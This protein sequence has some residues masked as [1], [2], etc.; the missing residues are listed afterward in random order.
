[1]PTPDDERFEVYL[2]QFRP[3]VPDP[4]PTEGR[5]QASRRSFVLR[6]WIAA[7]AAILIVGAISLH[8][9]SNRVAAP[10]T[11]SEAASPK[12]VRLQPLTMRSANALLA[13][14]PSFKAVVDDLAFRSESLTLPK[15]KQSALAV[16]GKEKIKL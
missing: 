1:V 4:M 16:L 14:A 13:T 7:V 6:A 10:N 3:L 2:K 5:R 11:A 9:R 15:G 12:V 8:I